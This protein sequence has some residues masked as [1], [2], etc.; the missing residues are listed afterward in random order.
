VKVTFTGARPPSQPLAPY[1][2][3]HDTYSVI[4][5]NKRQDKTENEVAEDKVQGRNIKW[6]EPSAKGE[7]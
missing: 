3:K 7:K 6:S 5:V 1:S 2:D 4:K